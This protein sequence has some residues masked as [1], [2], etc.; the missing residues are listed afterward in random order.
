MRFSRNEVT[1]LI[2]LDQTADVGDRPLHGVLPMTCS[3]LVEHDLAMFMGNTGQMLRNGLPFGGMHATWPYQTRGLESDNRVIT[4][5]LVIRLSRTL[6]FGNRILFLSHHHCGFRFTGEA[7]A[8]QR[9]N[10]TGNQLP[11]EKP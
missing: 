7:I 2:A 8:E 6:P 4:F 9:R 3:H 1:R 11:S 5:G 10:G